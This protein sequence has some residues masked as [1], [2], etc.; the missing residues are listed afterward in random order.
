MGVLPSKHVCVFSEKLRF[1]P[2]ASLLILIVL[3]G[4]K[5]QI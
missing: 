5:Q 3:G 1:P 2:F 4:L